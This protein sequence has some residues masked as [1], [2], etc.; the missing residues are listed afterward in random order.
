MDI[1]TSINEKKEIFSS[2]A[3]INTENELDEK[4]KEL[5]AGEFWYR[6]V[7]NASYKSYTS[8][9]RFW[10]NRNDQQKQFLKDYNEFINKLIEVE[11]KDSYVRK[12]IKEE[13]L[14]Y[15]EIWLLA[16]MQHYGIPSP[17]LDF[18]EDLLLGLFFAIDGAAPENK[19]DKDINQY[20]S[21]YYVSQQ[22]DW[23]E[24]TIQAVMESAA[25]NIEQMLQQHITQQVDSRSVQYDIRYLPFDSFRELRFVPVAGVGGHVNLSIPT[26]HFCCQ[27]DIINNRLKEQSGAF[28]M[29]NDET[30]PLFELM[31]DTC[32]QKLFNCIEINKNLIEHLRENYLKP[33]HITHDKVYD[34]SNLMSRNLT[35]SMKESESSVTHSAE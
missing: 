31:N 13:G 35:Q 32:K 11:S 9:Q 17:M 4:I 14:P 27:Y 23:I 18:S 34:E 30:I 26:L 15:T 2:Y 7:C 10:S 28:I 1:Y 3:I 22:V 6:G 12:Y 21:L 8:S 19:L 24:S 5:Q 25:K 33:R 20:V 29:N 16:L